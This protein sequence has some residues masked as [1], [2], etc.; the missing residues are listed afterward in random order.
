MQRHCRFVNKL[1]TRYKTPYFS[2]KN[3]NCAHRSRRTKDANSGSR[4]TN[5]IYL[6]KKR[7]ITMDFQ[8]DVS[9]LFIEFIQ[10]NNYLEASSTATAQATEEASK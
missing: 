1:L 2:H 8:S 7:H 6:N 4:Q 3:K 5:S 10:Q 9:D